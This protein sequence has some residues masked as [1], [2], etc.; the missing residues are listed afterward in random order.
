M[1]SGSILP[2]KIRV[3]SEDQATSEAALFLDGAAPPRGLV[4]CI[5]AI[6]VPARFYEQFAAEI[7]HRG[8]CVVVSELRGVGTSSIRARRGVDFGY[9]ELATLDLPAVINAVRS[10]FPSLPV[11]LLG[12]SIGA[13]ISAIHSVL[14]PRQVQGLVMVAAGTPYYRCWGFPK[15]IA[16]YGIV[17]LVRSVTRALGYFPGKRIGLFGT[18]A[19]QLMLE[20]VALAARGS[21][22]V[23]G[24]GVDLEAKL[25]TLE[26]PLLALSF[27]GDSFAPARAVKH[28]LEKMPEAQT[29]H[30]ELTAADLGAKSVNHLSWTK[31]PI[32]VADIISL[33]LDGVVKT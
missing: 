11:V 25:R 9:K 28:L 24:L 30:R 13:H 12:H 6:G 18:E 14:H 21:F 26:L 22:E 1:D 2:R 31:Y 5:P 17:Q 20:W 8:Y 32:R 29:I 3:V 4:I 33:W 15:N 16:M 27:E 7:A 10:E 19:R 23:G